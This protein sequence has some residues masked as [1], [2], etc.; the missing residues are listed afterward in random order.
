MDEMCLAAI[1]MNITEIGFTEHLDLHPL[2]PDTG[3]FKPDD[4]WKEIT[5][6]RENFKGELT[7]RAGIELSEP[8]QH[9]EVVESLLEKYPWDYTLGSL[10]WVEDRMIFDNAYFTVPEKDAYEKYF[11]ELQRMVNVGNFDILAH[12]DMVKRN[13]FENY[14]TF[15]P[16]K[17]EIQIRSILKTIISKNI[18]LEVNTGSLRRSIKE[19]SPSK[20]ILEWF[21]NE[22]GKWISFGS[23]AHSSE[24]LGAG[25]NRATRTVKDFGYKVVASFS[26]HQLSPMAFE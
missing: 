5:R 6:C 12:M 20:Q 3:F 19:T 11:M 25:L 4:W 17:Y 7:I 15:E 22:G 21:H 9:L 13:G 18:V 8:H 1:N 14:G 23:D 24:A 26:R 2:D 10:H 16:T